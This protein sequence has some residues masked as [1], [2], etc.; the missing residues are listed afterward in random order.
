MVR[1][2]LCRLCTILMKVSWCSLFFKILVYERY[3][4]VPCF[5]HSLLIFQMSFQ[6]LRKN[7]KV[8]IMLGIFLAGKVEIVC[9]GMKVSFLSVS[10]GHFMFSVKHS[11]MKFSDIR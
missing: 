5:T 7:G 4:Y 11:E 6:A 2:I 9:T 8:I 3:D 1:L 10:W